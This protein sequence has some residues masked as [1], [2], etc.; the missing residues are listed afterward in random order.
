MS[1][2]KKLIVVKSLRLGKFTLPMI[3]ASI[4]AQEAG[5]VILLDRDDLIKALPDTSVF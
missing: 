2:M 3:R 5:I 4:T 1:S